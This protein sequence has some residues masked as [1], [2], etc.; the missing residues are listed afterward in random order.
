MLP[1]LGCADLESS[2]SMWFR[3]D[4]NNRRKAEVGCRG[5]DSAWTIRCDGNE[6][7]GRVEN[8]SQGKL[9]ETPYKINNNII[10]K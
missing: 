5:S 1:V 4:R 3:R 10:K 9:I 7:K 8:C 6:W 2:P